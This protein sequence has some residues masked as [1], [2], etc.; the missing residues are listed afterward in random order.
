MKHIFFSFLLIL[1]TAVC[2]LPLQAQWVQTGLTNPDSDDVGWFAVS[3]NGAG[4]T[5]LF[6]VTEFGEVFLTTDNGTSWTPADLG[7]RSAFVLSL[8]V[9]PNGAGGANLFAGTVSGSGVYLSTDNG[10]SWAPANSG[11]TNAFV[12]CLAANP[13]GAGGTDLYAGTF[14]G[15]GVFLSTNN[16]AQWTP[17]DSGLTNGDIFS[18]GFSG[19]NLFAGT[20]GGVFLSTDNGTSWNPVDS[21]LTT[22]NVHTFA[23]VP[24]G[25]GGTS[26]LAGTD[27]GIFVSSDTGTA[28][29]PADSNLTNTLVYSLVANGSNIFAGTAGGVFV[30][31]NTGVS[32]TQVDSG[33]ANTTVY[34]L[35]VSGSNLFAGTVGGGVWRCPLSELTSVSTHP[36]QM[37]LHFSLSQN[38]PNP[39]NPTTA[40]EFVLP[41]RSFVTL[42]VYDI[43]GREAATIV[44]EELAAGSYTRQWNAADMASGVYFYRIQAGTFRETKRMLLL[45]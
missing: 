13:N 2:T 39:F 36:V 10:T 8:A 14:Y 43:L 31:T 3:P 38:Y 41:A 33:L 44:S 40:I 9:T 21:G 30:S 17:I 24:Q 22:T 7:I 1:T 6:A 25:A 37:P 27:D 16:G 29:T 28:W 11:L 15:K 35:V 26:L 12:L 32:W 18:I 23:A 19:T 4:G 34:S 5:N 42:K 20:A 45:K